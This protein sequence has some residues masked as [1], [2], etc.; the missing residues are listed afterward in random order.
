[1]ITLCTDCGERLGV[2]DTKDVVSE[3]HRKY[4]WGCGFSSDSGL[5]LCKEDVAIKKAK[6]LGLLK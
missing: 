3:C 4:C 5:T 6:E 1:M 2:N